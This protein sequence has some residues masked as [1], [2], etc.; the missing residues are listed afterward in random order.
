MQIPPYLQPGDTV[1]IVAP[2][3][4]F[5]YDDLQAAFNLLRHNWQLTVLEGAHL[6]AS[7]GAFAGTDAQRLADLQNAIND[8]SVRAIFAA[9]GG[10]GSYRL[11]EKLDFSPL[12]TNPKWLVGFS[13]ITVLLSHV[14]Q[15]GVASLHAI[16]PRQFR[17][18]GV[19]D[20]VESLR[21]WL[22]GETVAPYTAKP[23]PL[24]R[25][26][27]AAGT[28]TGGNLSMLLHTLGTS[29]EVDWA[30]KLLFIEDIDETV[31]SLDRMMIQ[32]RR[33][34]KLANLAGLLVGTFS[35]MRDNLTTPWGKTADQIIAEAVSMYTYPVAFGMPIGH[36]GR[37]LA[38]PVG[39]SGTLAVDSA[40]SILTF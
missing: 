30:G 5:P 18:D 35:D 34:G 13:D 8:P 29:S 12:L 33:S 10:Y 26:G 32:L 40:G 3:S 2:A 1:V 39:M 20:D 15:L 6:Q 36:E 17:L 31:F 22:F 4:P 23:N 24:N 25:E 7:T 27:G 9:R 11:V 16:M 21:Q 19:D 38:I 37:N 14:Q 28:L